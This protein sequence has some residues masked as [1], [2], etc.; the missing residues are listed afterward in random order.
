[1]IRAPL[2]RVAPIAARIVA[3]RVAP[4]AA[5]LTA[6][7]TAAVV[8]ALAAGCSAPAR[9]PF[10]TDGE[11][12]V[13]AVLELDAD[14]RVVAATGLAPLSTERGRSVFTGG[15]RHVAVGWRSDALGLALPDAD[16]LASTR[17]E[18][19]AGCAD[20]LPTP[21][22]AVE[23]ATGAPVD[24]A[25][26]PA[27]TAAWLVDT[28]PEVQVDRLSFDLE[29]KQFRCPTT[30]TPRSRCTF[31]VD[32]DCTFGRV[33]ATVHHDR[34]VCLEAAAPLTCVAAATEA[35]AAA[36]Y[37]CTEPEA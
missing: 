7:L 9:V 29:C 25:A 20:H 28:C 18:A 32:L 6:A 2:A 11:A 4:I 33:T 15:G 22:V 17:L 23:L 24:A 26:L 5:R 14:G 21:T 8:A 12:D 37:V 19:A 30:I 13:V 31:D 36:T 3:P 1:M 27:L 10:A 35:P 34:T 16:V